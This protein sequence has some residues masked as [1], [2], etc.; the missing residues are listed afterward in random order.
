MFPP[1]FFAA[2]LWNEEVPALLRLESGP[3]GGG[4]PGEPERGGGGGWSA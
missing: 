2:H 1:V 4:G 3:R